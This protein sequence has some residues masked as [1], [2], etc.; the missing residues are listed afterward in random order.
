MKITQTRMTTKLTIIMIML[1][2]ETAYGTTYYLTSSGAASAQLPASWNSVATG[3]GLAATTFAKNG[4]IFIIPSGISGTVSGNWIF[5]GGNN[6]T[7]VVSLTIDGSLTISSGYSLTIYAKNNDQNTVD[8]N[9]SLI[10]RGTSGNQLVA[11]LGGFATAAGNIVNING[12]STL[13]TPNTDGITGTNGSIN[14]TNMTLRFT[15]SSN[16]EF[17]GAGQATTGLPSTVANL[18]YSG[19]GIKVLSSPVTVNGTFTISNGGSQNDFTQTV[20]YGPAGALVYNVTSDIRVSSEW[21]LTFT[22]TGGVTIKGSATITLTGARVMG[23]STNVPLNILKGATL[24]T[25]AYSLTLNGD[26]VNSGTMN[27]GSSAIEIAGSVAGQNIAGF[28]TSG[29]FTI[30]KPAGGA[31]VLGNISCSTLALK[32][33]IL[34]ATSAV[35]MVRGSVTGGSSTSYV[36]GKLA[37]VIS[38]TGSQS[39]PIGKGGNYR[40]LSINCSAITGTGTF[41]AEQIEAIQPGTPPVNISLYSARYWSVSQS[42]ASSVTC[43]IGLD[44]TGYTPTGSGNVVIIRGD[45]K[46][47]SYVSSTFANPVYTSDNLTT[48]GNFCLGEAGTYWIGNTSDWFTSS[49][50]STGKVPDG[51]GSLYIPVT[52]KNFPVISGVSP[53]NDVSISGNGSL[54]LQ[55]GATLTVRQGPVLSIDKGASVITDGTSK[56]ILESD[57][58]FLN[59]SDGSPRLQANRKIN[60][61]SKKGWI[62]VA[63]PVTTTFSDLFKS[64]IVTQ[65][66][67]GSGYPSLQPNLMWWA[68]N[69]GGTSLQGWRSPSASSDNV[70]GGRG[71]FLYHFNGA[72]LPSPLT[73]NYP[74]IE[75]VSLNA[76]GTEF[77][78]SGNFS[79][80]V[81]KTPRA[82]QGSSIHSATAGEGWNLLGNPT[83]STLDWSAVSGWTKTNIDNTIY[84]WDDTASNGAG[85]YRYWNGNAAVSTLQDGKI[86]P[87]QAFWVHANAAAPSLSMNNNAK[88]AKAGTFIAKNGKLQSAALQYSEDVTTVSPEQLII[89]VKLEGNGM[90]TEAFITLSHDGIIGTDQG[91]V[92]RLEPMSDS[93]LALYTNSS[94]SMNDPLLVNNIP[95]DTSLTQIL[96]L[97]TAALS[98]G[99]KAGGAMKLSWSIP[100]TWPEGV[101]IVLMDHE[102]KSAVSMLD[103]SE[104]DFTMAGPRSANALAVNVPGMPVD[105]LGSGEGNIMVMAARSSSATPTPFSIVIQ[106]DLTGEK[107][108]YESLA[109]ELLPP[110][111]NPFQDHTML[112]FRLPE[113]GKVR[114]EVFDLSGKLIEVPV[115]GICEAGLNQV[116]WTPRHAFS[117]L[118]I[119]RLITGIQTL[120]TKGVRIY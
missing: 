93:W 1:C 109:A 3:S 13:I 114:I 55:D 78:S 117:G 71:Y 62:M 44:G 27:A 91:D 69:D 30:N 59:L 66:F 107:P 20:S 75:P 52:S 112:S 11:T 76:T 23:N 104:Y 2:M 38:A 96:P 85:N 113:R 87:F 15:G 72:P 43:K 56:I 94:V 40:P 111:P 84:I 118:C 45:G 95:F 110:A 100:A 34:Y 50:W 99:A 5:G 79:F 60:S 101:T 22:G 92:Y 28:T 37:R 12:T 25:E 120:T 24:A 35:V 53:S 105:L 74:D 103:V 106:R 116:N 64:P 102:S 29:T 41:T 48:F 67:P 58:G 16:F 98:S 7:V 6:A 33:G 65:G 39:F 81:T 51:T 26:F 83:A 14:T 119:I 57:A 32:S 63:S 90:T 61:G 10:F 42:G 17:N 77:Q 49:N 97:Y 89:P 68:E 70:S 82:S 88:S 73:G 4:D 86:A 31:N 47:N 108:L 19:S 18:T 9:G 80:T 54:T 115:D 46:T 21:P 36:S 8:V